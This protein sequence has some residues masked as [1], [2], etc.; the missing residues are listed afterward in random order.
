MLALVQQISLNVY[1]LHGTKL[2]PVEG[3]LIA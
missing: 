1:D 3:K 2:V